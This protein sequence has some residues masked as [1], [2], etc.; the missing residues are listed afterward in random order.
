MAEFVS[1][2]QLDVSRRQI[3]SIVLNCDQASVQGGGPAV[4]QG[5]VL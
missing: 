1:K 3:L 4:T 5:G 2:G